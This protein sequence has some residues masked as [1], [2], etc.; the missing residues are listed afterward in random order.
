MTRLFSERDELVCEVFVVG[1]V[2]EI[3]SPLF[4]PLALAVLIEEE[5]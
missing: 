5:G 1:V 2:F 3:D 4:E